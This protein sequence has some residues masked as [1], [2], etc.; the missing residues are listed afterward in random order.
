VIG[1]RGSSGG[2]WDY[3]LAHLRLSWWRET[4]HR[5]IDRFACSSR[6]G[7]R[8][9]LGSVEERQGVGAGARLPS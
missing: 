4:L 3:G 5:E 7:G 1:G 6:G 8:A 9:R 2:V